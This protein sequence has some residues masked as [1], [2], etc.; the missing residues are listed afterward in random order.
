[1]KRNLC[2]PIAEFLTSSK[3]AT[4]VRHGCFGESELGRVDGVSTS[5]FASTAQFGSALLS[6]R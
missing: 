6:A 4:E 2:D 5:N 1:M 3:I